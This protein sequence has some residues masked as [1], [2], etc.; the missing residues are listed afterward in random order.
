M[1]QAFGWIDR[2]IAL[3]LPAAANAFGIFLLRQFIGSTIPGELLE[4]GRIDGCSEIGL[5]ARIVL[6]LTRPAL[7][8]LGLITFVGSWNNFVSALV[9]LQS[10]ET[11][12]VQ[13]ALR[14]L[15]GAYDTDWGALFAGTALTVL[16][17]VIIFIFTSKQMIEGLMAG[18]LKG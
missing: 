7:G 9:I 13:L 18:S 12:T 3:W 10:K 16:P 1:M 5:F 11:S 14:A 2:P 15:Q 8:T 4:A 17:L 6:P